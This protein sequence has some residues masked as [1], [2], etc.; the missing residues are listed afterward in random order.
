LCPTGGK[1][2]AE[3]VPAR[4]IYMTDQGKNPDDP[5]N[6]TTLASSSAS[7]LTTSFGPDIWKAP[8]LPVERPPPE[9]RVYNYL[10]QITS[11]WSHVEH[12][13]DLVIWALANVQP[14]A[15][16]CITSQLM[17][18]YNRFKAIIALLKLHERNTQKKTEELT[19]KAIEL[20]QKANAPGDQR[21][22]SIHDPWYV[23]TGHNQTGQFK[24]MPHKDHRYG[25]HPVDLEFLE[26]TLDD[27]KKYSERVTAFRA[28]VLKMLETSA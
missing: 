17:G 22:R 6:L 1:G 26:K 10:G 15:G 8:I 28:D 13:L 23:F 20:S 4:E 24:A 11:D 19:K 2:Q 16:A 18:A 3:P 12:T 25:V 7:T 14:E 21:N 9:H 27:I 5:F